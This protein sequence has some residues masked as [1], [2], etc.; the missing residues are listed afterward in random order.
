MNSKL[1]MNATV[2]YADV[3]RRQVM[4]LPRI[5]KLLQDAAIAHANQ[6]GTGTQVVETREESW[7]LNRMSAAL[8]RYPEAG[9]PLRVE[10]WSSGIKGFKGY[11]DFRVYDAANQPV[12]TA[13]SLWLYVSIRTRSIVRVPREVAETFPVG[14]EPAWCPDL[15]AQEFAEPSASAQRV[16]VTL[17]YSDIDV[18]QH[19]NNAAYFDFI[20]TALAA[21][22][23]TPHP[24]RVRLK[25]AKAIPAEA[26]SATLRLEPAGEGIRFAVE[27]DGVVHAIGDAQA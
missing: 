8:A 17:R 6:F 27:T 24:R 5:F 21:S 14:S 1:V 12:I 2:A 3:D 16:P 4:L 19:V 23:A 22:A 25:Y 26:T 15:E 9:E 13:S 18:N 10:T 11:R 20:Q 7:M